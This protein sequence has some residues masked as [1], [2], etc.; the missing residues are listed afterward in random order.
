MHSEPLHLLQAARLLSVAILVLIAAPSL[1]LRQSSQDPASTVASSEVPTSSPNFSHRPPMIRPLGSGPSPVAC[2]APCVADSISA[3]TGDMAFDSRTDETFVSTDF[4]TTLP[5]SDSGVSNISVLADS[6]TTILSTF[7]LKGSLVS[8]VYDSSASTIIAGLGNWNSTNYEWT[9][10]TNLSVISDSTDTVIA[11][12]PLM[13]APL[14]MAYDSAKG[15]VYVAEQAYPGNPNPPNIYNL[16]VISVSTGRLVANLPL[17]GWTTIGSP[18]YDPVRGE[19]LLPDPEP[20]LIDVISDSNNTVIGTVDLPTASYPVMMTYDPANGEIFVV[21]RGG[22]GT[23]TVSVISDSNDSVVT[24]IAVGSCPQAIA[25]D[26]KVNEVFVTNS[27]SNNVSVISDTTDQVV[28]S[29]LAGPLGSKPYAISV[30]YIRG[31]VF[32]QEYPR[33]LQL[34]SDGSDVIFSLTATP[35]PLT[36]GAPVSFTTTAGGPV[37]LHYAYS[38]LPSG[39][40]SANQSVLS[41]TPTAAGQY[42]VTVYVNTSTASVSASL[43]LNIATPLVIT[44]FSSTLN[45]VPWTGTTT[46]QTSVSGGVAPYSY[47]Y[48]GLPQNCLTRNAPSITC[49]PWNSGN[50]SVQVTVNDS[51]GTSATATTSFTVLPST[52]RASLS[53][54]NTTPLLG[55]SIEFSANASG[56]TPGYT[57]NYSGMPPGCVSSNTATIGC[58]PTQTGQYNVTLSVS[59]QDRGVAHAT[60]SL[61]VVFDFTVVGPSSTTVG[62]SMTIRVDSAMGFGA[63]SYNYSGLPPGCHDVNE[64]QLTCVPTQTGTYAVLIQVHDQGGHQATHT[65]SLTVV[66]ASGSNWLVSS[67]VLPYVVVSGIVAAVLLVAYAYR[68]RRSRT[69]P[70]ASETTSSSPT[71]HDLHRATEDEGSIKAVNRKQGNSDPAKDRSL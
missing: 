52:L 41:C 4:S 46:L 17:T 8:L 42:H 68:R 49:S 44:S 26:S 29:F 19:V 20:N 39:C 14:S 63:L 10:P 59:D 70:P 21:N 30:D 66:P 24:T 9:Y 35:S 45:P 11:V 65:F 53:V 54:T 1:P 58:L 56:G 34:S 16:S 2:A 36:L 12:I 61:E 51:G 48:A 15:E 18:L 64:P 60:V 37:G 69:G 40:L 22:C 57:F 31:E 71:E 47:R 6:N 7:Q 33:L 43:N 3:W 5:T 55:Q 50:Y 13:G 25:Y 62:S 28:G 27:D 32:I 67:G 38:G 23:G